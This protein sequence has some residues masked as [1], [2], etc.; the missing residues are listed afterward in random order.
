MNTILTNQ[1]RVTNNVPVQYRLV[2]R[3]GNTILQG[4][5]KWQEDGTAGIEWRDIPTVFEGETK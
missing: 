5:Y 3:T 2:V 1:G 4:A